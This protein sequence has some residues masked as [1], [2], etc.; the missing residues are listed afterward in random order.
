MYRV[1]TFIC[2]LFWSMNGFTAYEIEKKTA[3]QIE[4]LLRVEG[5]SKGESNLFENLSEIISQDKAVGEFSRFMIDLCLNPQK[6]DFTINDINKEECVLESVEK[7]IQDDLAFVLVDSFS[8]NPDAIV[9]EKFLNDYLNSYLEKMKTI[10]E[11]F[12]SWK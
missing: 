4:V 12:S 9:V 6:Y 5:V 1:I 2:I 3:G 10:I 8:K 11:V 7:R